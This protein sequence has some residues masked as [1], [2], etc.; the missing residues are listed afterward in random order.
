MPAPTP[1][2]PIEADPAYLWIKRNLG[3]PDRPPTATKTSFRN[4]LGEK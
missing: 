4:V 2:R 1:E 3:I